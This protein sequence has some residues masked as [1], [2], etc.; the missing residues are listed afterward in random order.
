MPGVSRSGPD[1]VGDG[2]VPPNA[3]VGSG[4]LWRRRAGQILRLGDVDLGY[5]VGEVA[6]VVGDEAVG[7]GVDCG[8]EVNGVRCLQL[9]GRSQHD[10]QVRDG[11][12]DRSELE[13]LIRPPRNDVSPFAGP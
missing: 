9:V 7:A 2:D 11:L 10:G 6:D 5:A 13:R 8:G 3:A 1:G 4:T 12:V